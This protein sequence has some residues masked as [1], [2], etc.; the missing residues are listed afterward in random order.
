VAVLNSYFG[1]VTGV[2]R[3]TGG[4][5]NKFGGDSTMAIFGAP[6]NAPPAE[7]ARKAIR[8]ALIIRAR[9]AEFNARRVESGQPPIAVGIGIS[10][11]EVITGNIGSAERFE[12]TVIGDAVNTAARVQ[13]LT[14]K[15]A[16]SAI[17]I[18]EATLTALSDPDEFQVADHG[19][20]PLKGKAKPVRVYG[21]VGKRLTQ[22]RP[23]L[24]VG[25]VPRPDILEALYLY[26][27]GFSVETVAATKKASPVDVGRWLQGAS[28][29]FG[30]ASQEL[31]LSFELTD[32]E[33]NR[34]RDF[35]ARPEMSAPLAASL[36]IAS[37]L[38]LTAAPNGHGGMG[39]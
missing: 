3:E 14:S 38:A 22:G 32:A 25:D 37:V 33:L 28:E 11:G 19:P 9:L 34:L 21:V 31:K 39:E 12:Y 35:K 15:V 4:F 8:A 18:T 36:P 2:I 1:V 5:V 27:R 17:L 29:Y 30:A 13:G 20:I 16:E 10:T 24:R 6:V 26:C 7:T 23:L